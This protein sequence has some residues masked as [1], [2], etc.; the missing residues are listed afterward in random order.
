VLGRTGAGN[1]SFAQVVTGQIATAAVTLAKIANIATARILGRV[2][3]ASGVIEE[4]TGTQ[5]TTLLDVFTSGLKGL[6]PASGGGTTN[7]LRADATWAAP[8]GGG[9]TTLRTTANQT[10]NAGA[11]VFTDITGLTFTVVSGTDY[12]FKF[13]IVFQS[14]ATTT[15]W[16]ASVNHPGGTVDHFTTYQTVV[17][18][19]TGATG[20]LQKHNTATDDMSLL[21]S[22]ITAAVNL[23]CI[24]EGCYKCTANGTFAARFANE[25]AANTD[26]VVQKGSWG[27]WF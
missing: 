27:M 22:T 2:T 26:I 23:V 24:I 4:L 14:A 3:A 8:A 18:S 15:G 20:W 1:L 16:K 13:Y 10:I 9:I 5:A 21:T 11:A 12:A 19:A 6:A 7:F 17:N 25:L